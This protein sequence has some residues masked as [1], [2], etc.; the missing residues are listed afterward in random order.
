MY[1]WTQWNPRPCGNGAPPK[2]IKAMWSFL[3]FS[4]FYRKFIPS[5]SNTAGPFLDLIKES[6]PWA[7]GSNQE[8]AF[9]NL[10]ATFTWQPVLAFPDTFKPFTLMM[11][12]SLMASGAVLMQHNMNR[13]KTFMPTEHNYNIFNWELLPI[14]CSIEE[15]R[16]YLLGSS[17]SVKVLTDHKNL[18][19]FKEPRK[20]LWKQAQWLFFLQDFNLAYHTLPDTQMAPMDVLSRWDDVNTSLDNADVQL[21]PSNAFNQQIQAINVALTN[22][23]KDSFSSDP[24]VLQAVY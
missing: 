15:W 3:G 7:W 19:Y 4:S 9:Q 24:L 14:I 22:K 1:K 16:Q 5:F 8:K 2:T 21:L 18:T 6:T 23:I 20:L 17:F 11:N 10:Q 13:D 12:A